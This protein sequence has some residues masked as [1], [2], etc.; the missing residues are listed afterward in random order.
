MFYGS[1]VRNSSYL[2][3]LSVLHNIGNL[4]YKNVFIFQVYTMALR[5]SALAEQNMKKIL[6][7]INKKGKYCN[8]FISW[9]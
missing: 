3:N 1:A 9:F 2:Q 4:M 6:N 5:L 8:T 7:S